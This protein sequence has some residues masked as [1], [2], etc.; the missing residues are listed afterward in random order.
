MF[1]YDIQRRRKSGHPDSGLHLLVRH[2]AEVEKGRPHEVVGGFFPNAIEISVICK[3][4]EPTD[5]QS[6]VIQIL[7]NH[8]TSIYQGA[9]VHYV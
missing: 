2:N 1:N 6:E 9:S 4:E 5:Q 3:G 7:V 8:L